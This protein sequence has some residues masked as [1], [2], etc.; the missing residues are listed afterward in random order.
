MDDNA[1]I[2]LVVLIMS[3]TMLLALRVAVNA[4]R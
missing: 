2:V 1:T 4:R 3:V